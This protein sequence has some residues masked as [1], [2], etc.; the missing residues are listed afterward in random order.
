MNLA[1]QGYK[2][3]RAYLK[4]LLLE[5]KR[6]NPSY[7]L[8]AFARDLRMSPPRLSEVINGK[9]GLSIGAA[10]KIS[11]ALGHNESETDF[12]CDWVQCSDARSPEARRIAQIR[13]QKYNYVDEF[14]SLKEDLFSLI[15]DWYH[16]GILELTFVRGFRS[17]SAWIAKKLGISELEADE[18][19]KR[20]LRMGLLKKEDDRFIKVSKNYTTTFDVP[21]VAIRKFNEQMLAKAV[22]ALQTHAVDERD[23]STITMAT[24]PSKLVIAKEMIRKFRRNLSKELET[25]DRSELYCFSAQLFRLSKR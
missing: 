18:A 8:R 14:E 1:Q 3:Y 15:S 10:I 13:M 17:N 4:G 16:Y 23:F 25:G 5:R 24:D 22:I 7:S 2:D 19:I 11:G 6:V 20:L 9:K 12:F 21:S